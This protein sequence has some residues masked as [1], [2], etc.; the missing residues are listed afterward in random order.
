M[1]SS[2]ATN[3]SV[4]SRNGEANVEGLLSW[5]E[6]P[7]YLPFALSATRIHLTPTS[8]QQTRQ[9]FISHKLVH[10]SQIRELPAGRPQS[11]GWERKGGLW[12]TALPFAQS[13]NLIHCRARYLPESFMSK[14]HTTFQVKKKNGRREIK[15]RWL[16]HQCPAMT[17]NKLMLGS[18]LKLL[19]PA[20]G[21]GSD[22]VHA[23]AVK[24]DISTPNSSFWLLF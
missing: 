13:T 2:N 17:M 11:K 6:G 12:L 14:T 7:K 23:P 5:F 3:W 15:V 1:A 19:L 24:W 20:L 21:R 10:Q 4:Y 9:L 18:H 22:I 16:G 8:Y